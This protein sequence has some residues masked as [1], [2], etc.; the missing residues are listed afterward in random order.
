MD[1]S[2]PARLYAGVAGFALV[3][4]GIIGFFYSAS[5]GSPGHVA[6]I[7][8]ILDVNGWHNVLFILTGVLGLLAFSA[9]VHASRQYALALG[10]FYV[11]VAVWG[12][13][14]G[15]GDSIL[16]IVPVNAEDDYFHLLVG[17]TGLAAGLATAEPR[18]VAA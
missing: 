18:T 14:I 5:F 16:S 3:V 13:I 10:V 17:L 8:G 4:L 15:G 2:S 1:G 7:F 9:G 12:F 11:V 6:A